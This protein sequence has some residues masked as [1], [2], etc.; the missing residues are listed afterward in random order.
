[1]LRNSALLVFAVCASAPLSTLPAQGKDARAPKAVWPDEGPFTWAG[2]TTSSD[3]SANDLRTRL[4]PFA[5]DSMEGRRIGE[6]GNYKGT[7]YI[8]AEFARLGL[9]PAGDDG[10]YFQDLPFGPTAYDVAT[11][12][13]AVAGAPLTVKRDWIPLTPV[14]G[15]G[16]SANATLDKVTTI[17]AGRWGDS[18]AL[19][20]ALF[21]G[22]IA[23]FLATPNAPG[24]EPPSRPAR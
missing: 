4:Y 20:P 7:A 9:K 24:M 2:K 10:T 23:V 22:K 19:D 15:G 11:T 8:A 3:I 5:H 21:R 12:R 18:T 16:L 1:M 17:F 14:A 13:L 6:R